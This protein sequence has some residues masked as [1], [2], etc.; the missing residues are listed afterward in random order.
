MFYSMLKCNMVYFHEKVLWKA[1]RC[2]YTWSRTCPFLEKAVANSVYFNTT[3]VSFLASAIH[4]SGVT[5]ALKPFVPHIKYL[6]SPFFRT[7]FFGYITIGLSLIL[8]NVTFSR[9]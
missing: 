1:V 2:R 6:Q 5:E 9:Y 4:I 8:V 3:I 7:S